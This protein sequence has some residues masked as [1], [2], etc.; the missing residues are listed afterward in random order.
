MAGLE[1]G[2]RGELLGRLAEVVES[3]NPEHPTRV[4]VDGRPASGKTTL[5]DELAAVLRARGRQVIRAT[6]DEFLF[7]RSQR[8]RRGEYSA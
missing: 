4:A 3:V 1:S 8:Y 7:P 5:A 2:T 6:I